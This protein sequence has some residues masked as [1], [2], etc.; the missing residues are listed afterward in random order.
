MKEA[1]GDWRRL[2]NAGGDG[3]IS[4]IASLLAP[5]PA[6]ESKRDEAIQP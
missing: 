1:L 3:A 2:R 5:P 6:A 4:V